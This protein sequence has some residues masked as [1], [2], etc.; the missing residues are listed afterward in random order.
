MHAE[1]LEMTLPLVSPPFFERDPGFYVT[2]VRAL[3]IFL[4]RR[5]EFFADV[6]GTFLLEPLSGLRAGY[7][8][9]RGLQDR[10]ITSL[11]PR[12]LTSE[13]LKMS[14]VLWIH[15]D[16]SKEG[17]WNRMCN[18]VNQEIPHKAMF[19]I[20]LTAPDGKVKPE[21]H[22]QSLVDKV[23]EIRALYPLNATPKI[24]FVGHSSGGFIIP[25]LVKRLRAE[26]IPTGALLL[27][28]AKFDQQELNELADYPEPFLE[29]LGTKDIWVG[30]KS[31]RPNFMRIIAAHVSLLFNEAVITKVVEVL[32]AT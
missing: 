32:K 29:I 9:H 23:K 8:M 21:R 3:H 5:W 22:L 27:I 13:Q 26:A 17:I 28:G 31:L 6:L 25:P 24:S 16:R 15:G 19:T 20:N 4:S 14:P 18:R 1:T 10:T 7:Y 2:S 11:N 30:D 12:Q